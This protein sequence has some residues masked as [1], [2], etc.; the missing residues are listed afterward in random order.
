ML[1]EFASE[2]EFFDFQDI[3]HEFLPK[4]DFAFHYFLSQKSNLRDHSLGQMVS[5]AWYDVF[6]N[7]ISSRPL[8]ALSKA[9]KRLV[10]RIMIDA[11]HSVLVE[12]HRNGQWQSLFSDEEQFLRSH[13]R[14]H[15]VTFQENQY[16]FTLEEEEER[17]GEEICRTIDAFEKFD[18][19]MLC[20]YFHAHYGNVD[21]RYAKECLEHLRALYG[22]D[23]YARRCQAAFLSSRRENQ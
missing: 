1:H 12:R 10:K 18:I 8:T 17:L 21:Q 14:H 11:N 7:Y 23:D 19:E 20:S 3:F 16:S 22:P 13:K 15:Q 4:K 6:Q 9:K 2:R 5:K